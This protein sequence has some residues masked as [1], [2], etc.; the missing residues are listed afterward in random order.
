MNVWSEHWLRRGCAQ[1][2]ALYIEEVVRQ[3]TEKLFK[4]K[5]LNQR[6]LILIDFVR[7]SSCEFM[8]GKLR[9]CAGDKCVISQVEI[10]MNNEFTR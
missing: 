5:Y 9:Y 2:L 1:Y 7:K 4:I 8:C 10:E 3:D 6:N